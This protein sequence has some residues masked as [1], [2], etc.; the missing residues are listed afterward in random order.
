MQ[1]LPQMERPRTSRRSGITYKGKRISNVETCQTLQMQKLSS[2]ARPQICNQSTASRE[3]KAG[4]SSWVAASFLPSPTPLPSPFLPLSQNSPVPR[5]VTAG[6]VLAWRMKMRPC[7]HVSHSPVGVTNQ[8]QRWSCHTAQGQ[9]ITEDNT[10]KSMCVCMCTCIHR[11]R[12]KRIC[13]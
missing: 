4:G 11:Y 9:T 2:Q 1:F 7:S 3:L 6:W 12:N 8:R 5:S 13:T 10:R